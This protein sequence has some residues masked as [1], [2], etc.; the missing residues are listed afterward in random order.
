MLSDHGSPLQWCKHTACLHYEALAL[1][2]DA[3]ID[4]R[5]PLDFSR[6]ASVINM[7]RARDI[8]KFLLYCDFEF[9]HFQH[10]MGRICTSD[11]LDFDVIYETISEL[12]QVP[13]FPIPLQDFDRVRPSLH[14]GFPVKHHFQL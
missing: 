7:Q 12:C 3:I 9:G 14:H 4:I 1:S 2:S 13:H 6:P 10:F 8:S 5:K 11:F